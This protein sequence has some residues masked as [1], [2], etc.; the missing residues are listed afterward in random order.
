MLKPLGFN[1]K[2]ATFAGNLGRKL[3]CG[4]CGSCFNQYALYIDNYAKNFTNKYS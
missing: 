3:A 1:C 2:K 4:V